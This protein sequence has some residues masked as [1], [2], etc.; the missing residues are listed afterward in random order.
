MAALGESEDVI[1]LWDVAEA[2]KDSGLFEKAL[3]IYRRFVTVTSPRRHV[4]AL[5]ECADRSDDNKALLDVCK[6]LRDH[7]V[8]LE[9]VIELEAVTRE[10]YDD[11]D[12]AVEVL[13]AYLAL[14]TND[15]FSRLVN[16]RK[17]VLGIIDP[18]APNEPHPEL[19]P[20]HVV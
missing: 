17:A 14:Q 20:Y 5:L 10:K 9:E 8:I 15:Y 12:G 13:D 6:N 2:C 1:C 19:A 18:C 7:G 4:M 16:L 11:V 3:P